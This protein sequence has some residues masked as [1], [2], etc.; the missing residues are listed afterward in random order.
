MRGH[1]NLGMA[2]LDVSPLDIFPLC[3]TQDDCPLYNYR[4]SADKMV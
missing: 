1:P 3:H 2:P 4:V